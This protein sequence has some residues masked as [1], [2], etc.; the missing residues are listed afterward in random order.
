MKCRYSY[1]KHN[2]EINKPHKKLK[3]ACDVMIMSQ[4]KILFLFI[5][6][7]SDIRKFSFGILIIMI[8]RF[9][10]YIQLITARQIMYVKYC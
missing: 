9:E 10:Y 8:H 5:G 2:S 1:N 3:G 7:Y 6:N 4:V